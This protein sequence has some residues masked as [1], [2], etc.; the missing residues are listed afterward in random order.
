MQLL[1]LQGPIYISEFDAHLADQQ[2]V[3]LVRPNDTRRRIV[4]DLRDQRTD[5]LTLAYSDVL[6]KCDKLNL[7]LKGFLFMLIRSYS[8]T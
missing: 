4:T 5:M 3:I 7:L 2:P 8:T 6:R 1:A